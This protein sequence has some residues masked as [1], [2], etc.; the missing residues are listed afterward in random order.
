MSLL[1]D[2]FAFLSVIV[3]GL[4]IAAQS[5]ALGGV[6]FLIAMA[7]PLAR[8]VEGPAIA[9]STARIAGWAAVALAGCEAMTLALQGAVLVETV[10]LS[11]PDV[12]SADFAVASL[13]K[14]AAAIVLA[15]ALRQAGSA[16]SVPLLLTAGAIVLLAA[17]LTT[18]AAAR[19]DGRPGLLMAEALHQLGAAIWVGGIPAFVMALG[20]I[21]DGA[22]WRIVGERFSRL[23][24]TGVACLLV[25]G[26]AMAIAYVGSFDAFYGTAFGVMVGA[27]I[28]LFGM[29]LLLGLGN[30][31]VVRR[32]RDDPG[33]SVLRMKRF[34]EVE[35]GIGFSLFFA[36]ASLTSV[37]PAIDMT[38]D[39]VDW[40]SVVERNT[41]TWP[42]LSSPDRDTLMLATV[43]SQLDA[44]AAAHR[45]APTAAYVPGS[46]IMPDRNAADVA[47]SEYNHHWAGLFVAA[48]GLLALASQAGVR[49][50]RHWPLLFLGLA[51]F[52]FLRSDP[53]VW[54]LG[55]VGFWSSLR[56]V[57]VLQHKFFVA[58]T[59]VFAL[60]EWRV[61][62][63]G[64]AGTRAAYVFPLLTALGGA[65]LLTHTHAI[66]NV[67]E[68]LLIELTHTPLA[69]LGILAGWA[70]WLELRLDGRAARI[71]GWAWPFCFLL[72]GGVLL[73][74]R[75]A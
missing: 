25:S 2:L 54:P 35:I 74:Y 39:R 68:Q 51:M 31:L 30:F 42:R 45:T 40:A 71:A 7:G 1:V 41:P 69:L 53:E 48:V 19:L 14:I 36:A 44:N 63:G 6:V 61:R 38:N 21:H 11:V 72:I 70:R 34:A 28:A 67:R 75:E 43:Q 26:V 9:A 22:G 17:T 47:W 33:A 64:L 10:E 24:M 56:D 52:L 46:G 37:P 5:V 29:L 23:S 32:L 60:F 3:H 15:A 55:P 49:W 62:A 20:R 12:L 58:L 13:V 4:T 59:V 57:E 18:H 50:S 65:A 66:A 8:V 73:L 16:A 27:K